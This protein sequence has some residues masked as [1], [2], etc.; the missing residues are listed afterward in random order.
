MRADRHQRGRSHWPRALDTDYNTCNALYGRCSIRLG[1]PRH[2]S[3]RAGPGISRAWLPAY[4][5]CTGQRLTVRIDGEHERKQGRLPADYVDG[6]RGTWGSSLLIFAG[7]WGRRCS[8]SGTVY[9]RSVHTVP[10]PWM[11]SEQCVPCEAAACSCDGW[12]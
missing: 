3:T 8:T 11:A 6:G 2:S 12:C 1:E 4:L 10:G 5:P 9:R 7:S